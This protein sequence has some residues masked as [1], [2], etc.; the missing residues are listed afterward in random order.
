MILQ[1]LAVQPVVH[2]ALRACKVGT[3]NDQR[4][5]RSQELD[6]F[7]YDVFRLRKV[8]DEPERAYYIIHF[9]GYEAEEISADQPLDGGAIPHHPRANFRL[10]ERR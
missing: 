6:V 4:A 3:R 5:S 9:I 8:F 7:D 1:I 2:D 10:S